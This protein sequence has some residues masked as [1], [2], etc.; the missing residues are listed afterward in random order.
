MK[1]AIPIWN[2]RISPV[3]DCAR[4]MIVVDIEEGGERQRTEYNLDELLFL[5]RASYLKK[6][7]IDILICGAISRPLEELIQTKGIK[8]VSYLCGNVEEILQALCNDRLSQDQFLMPGCC[9]RRRSR[10]RHRGSR[11]RKKGA[12]A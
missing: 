9:G 12:T 5:Q 7:N 11:C 3:F 2:H 1:V 10:F 4:K 6:L 8:I